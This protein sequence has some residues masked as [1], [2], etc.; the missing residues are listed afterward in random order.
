L[1]GCTASSTDV[2]VAVSSKSRVIRSEIVDGYESRYYGQKTKLPVFEIE[3]A[4]AGRLTTEITWNT[5]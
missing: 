3:V 2:T 1:N 5:I 4:E